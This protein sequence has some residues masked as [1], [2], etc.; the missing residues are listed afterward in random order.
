MSTSSTASSISTVTSTTS[1]TII[2]DDGSWS[3]AIRSVFIYGSGALRLHLSRTAGTLG[4]RFVVISSTIAADSISRAI[5]NAIN[6]PH[7]VKNHAG[8]NRE[9]KSLT[10]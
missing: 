5:T 6:E 8:I 9:L 4:T 2:H 1:T 3:N 7:Y 10:Q